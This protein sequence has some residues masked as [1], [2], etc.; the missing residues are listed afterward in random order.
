MH[1]GKRKH[2]PRDVGVEIA[3]AAPIWTCAAG[4]GF[5]AWWFA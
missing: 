5:L 4:L 3:M 2:G 1:V